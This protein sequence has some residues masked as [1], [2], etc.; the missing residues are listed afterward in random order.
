[1]RIA[2]TGG[3]GQLVKSLVE[4]GA[5]SG[6]EVIPV[7]RPA[8]DLAK[9]DTVVPAILATTPDL[10]V[11][12]A[13]YTAVD[14]AESEPDLAMSINSIGAG[15][16]AEAAAKAGVPVLHLSTE[17]IFDGSKPTP[18]C[19]SDLPLPLNVY[20]VTKLQGELQ[21]AAVTD[22]HVILRTSWI[23]SPF[24]ANF[25]TTMFGIAKTKENV[26]VVA[27]QI[28]RPT[29]ALDIADSILKI[30]QRLA[31]DSS[32]ELRGVFNL[33]S[34]GEASWADFAESIFR[35][36]EKHG[37]RSC[38]VER[39]TSAEYPTPAVRPLNCRLNGD[40]IQRIYGVALPHWSDK[41]DLCI[42]RL[43]YTNVAQ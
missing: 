17:Y 12:A 1:M 6:H 29:C 5:K 32:R 42:S 30:G 3:R 7:A 11:S 21:V 15:S 34:V 14:R 19:E 10:V 23:Y 26:R 18:Y 33:A 38:R 36:S 40:K 24:G 9:P 39:I 13:A 20:G 4:R 37:Q 35:S 8:L 43:T 16:V 31:V 41:I 28:G 2:I 27:D 22:N 25:L